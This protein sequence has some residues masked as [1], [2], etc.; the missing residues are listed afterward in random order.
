MKELK[1]TEN[2]TKIEIWSHWLEEPEALYKYGEYFSLK[3]A[4]E[5][6]RDFIYGTCHEHEYIVKIIAL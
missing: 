6:I 5:V 3:E 4:S 1:E 2:G